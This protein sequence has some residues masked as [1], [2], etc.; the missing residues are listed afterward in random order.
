[1]SAHFGSEHRPTPQGGNEVRYYQSLATRPGAGVA[2]ALGGGFAR[3]F[4]HL[5]VLEVLEETGIPISAIAGTS[6]GGI[7]GAAYADGV[8][9]R[10][11]CDLGRNIRIRDLIRFQRS[12]KGSPAKDCIALFLRDWVHA[13]RV[14]ELRIPTA[15]VTTNVDTCGAHVFTRGPLEIALRASCAFPGLFPPIEYEGKLL[16]DGCIAAPVPA[17]IAAR[18]NSMC[19]IAVDV[20]SGGPDRLPGEPGRLWARHADILLGPAVQQIG[21]D[22]FSSVD[23]ARAAGAESM[24]R[25][26]PGVRELLAGRMEEFMPERASADMRSE[27]TLL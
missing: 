26:L 5:G 16:A 8:A 13:L 27:L 10:D 17:A 11:L 21:W 1:M 12:E 15:V 14:E 23:E 3:G 19:V 6:I 2:L 24:R 25:A 9:I 7:L 20:G 18:M 22:D 4:A